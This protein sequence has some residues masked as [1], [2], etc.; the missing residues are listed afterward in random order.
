MDR[1]GPASARA[2]RDRPGPADLREPV[3]AV[4]DGPR[5][6]RHEPGRLQRQ[7]RRVRLRRY[8][9]NPHVGQ[10]LL[11]RDARR[12]RGHAHRHFEACPRVHEAEG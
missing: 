9:K 12:L 10:G 3:G 8:Q 7:A 2:V 5:V 6:R 11:R 4:Y 1:N